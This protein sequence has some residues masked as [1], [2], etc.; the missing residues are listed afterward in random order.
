MTRK[1]ILMVMLIAGYFVFILG[2]LLVGYEPGR[3]IGSRFAT[4][5]VAM[6]KI[7][8][9]AFI[10]IGLFEVWVDRTTIENHL[11]RDARP[12][13]YLWSI[14]LAGTT[15]GGL[16]V[17]FPFAYSLHAKGA[18]LGI[19]FTYLGCAAVCRAPMT[20]FEA[21]FLGLRFSL[22]RLVVSLPLVVATSIVLGRFLE[23]RGYTVRPGQ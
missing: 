15:V 12:I 20:L 4:F 13:G 23:K 17:A 16:Y 11:G 7:L 19:V 2:S 18:K 21:S 5:A 9:C 10:L 8:P 3:Q 1:T 22:V 14:L 6:V